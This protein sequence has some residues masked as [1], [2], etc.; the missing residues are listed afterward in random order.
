MLLYMVQGAI[1]YM[2]VGPMCEKLW[3]LLFWGFWLVLSQL[4]VTWLVEVEN[5]MLATRVRSQASAS[6]RMSICCLALVGKSVVTL[7][8]PGGVH[9]AAAVAAAVSCADRLFH[10]SCSACSC[11]RSSLQS[12]GMRLLSSLLSA[13]GVVPL[14]NSCWRMKVVLSGP[15]DPVFMVG[16]QVA[17]AAV[18]LSIGSTN[19]PAAL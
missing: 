16:K 17:A 14:P 15:L 7:T 1:W 5:W 8:A 19:T 2:D 11:T 18:G 6:A 3:W 12:L 9:L 13:P 4:C 10:P